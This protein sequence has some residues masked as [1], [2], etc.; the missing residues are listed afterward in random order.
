MVDDQ[1]MF[2]PMYM[3][4]PVLKKG[5][6]SRFVY[7]PQLPK[8]QTWV[9]VFTGVTTNT[10]SG[11]QNISEPTPLETFPLYRRTLSLNH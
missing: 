5:A 6:S 11:S 2:G 7:L 9:N 3:V 10:Q 4:A 1:Q 8:D